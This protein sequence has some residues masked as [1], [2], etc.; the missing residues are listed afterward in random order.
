MLVNGWSLNEGKA[1]WTGTTLP[2]K[3]GST[4]TVMLAVSR[5]EIPEMMEAV[6]ER[7]MR[8]NGIPVMAPSLQESMYLHFLLDGIPQSTMELG[9]RFDQPIGELIRAE[10][11]EPIA[12]AA[13]DLMGASRPAPPQPAHPQ[14]E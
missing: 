12:Q 9:G 2:D 4:H 10:R 5:Q 14:P 1:T 8:E 13:L 7:S 3:A 6:K 11:P